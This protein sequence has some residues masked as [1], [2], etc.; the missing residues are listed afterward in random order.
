MRSERTLRSA[1]GLW[2]VALIALSIAVSLVGCRGNLFA[3]DGRSTPDGVR[4]VQ[5]Y[6]IV[7]GPD[8]EPVTRAA[9]YIDPSLYQGGARGISYQHYGPVTRVP[10]AV[11]APFSIE[12]SLPS[13]RR[14]HLVLDVYPAGA[15]TLVVKWPPVNFR[16]HLEWPAT[17]SDDQIVNAGVDL[18]ARID[19]RSAHLPSSEVRTHWWSTRTELSEGRTFLAALP[20]AADS[21]DY[22]RARWSVSATDSTPS[23]DFEASTPG[24]AFPATTEMT[25]AATFVPLPLRA[26]W[27]GG[28]FELEQYDLTTSITQPDGSTEWVK[29]RPRR[30]MRA[31]TT[32]GWPGEMK[33]DLV[34]FD[35]AAL[36]PWREFVRW[37]GVD[38]IVIEL[39]SH[40]FTTRVVDGEGEPFRFVEFRLEALAPSWDSMVLTTGLDGQLTWFVNDGDYTLDFVTGAPSSSP[41][42][43]PW[44]VEGDLSV[45]WVVP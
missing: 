2:S 13:P 15:E 18:A 21:V 45:T 33:I 16:V 34:P 44:R 42:G 39:G 27:G 3:P 43:G 20:A 4:M 8:G 10:E 36:L 41:R 38:E 11:Q 12:V 32:W 30:G 28:A 25:V 7:L 9:I 17:F 19:N 1:F 40:V 29:V 5:P 6:L 22:V 26:V 31:S 37:N 23:L 35:Q 24:V 14:E